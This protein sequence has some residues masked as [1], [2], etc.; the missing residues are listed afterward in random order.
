MC[1]IGGVGFV[2]QNR[3]WQVSF[4]KILEDFFSM[5]QAG[6]DRG[7][8]GTGVVLVWEDGTFA[9]FAMPVAADQFIESRG[10]GIL[11]MALKAQTEG[12][13]ISWILSCNRAQPIPE[14]DS[15]EEENLQPL[16][17]ADR[18]GFHNGT[19][20]N[21]HELFQQYALSRSTDVDSEVFLR[22]DDYFL[23]AQ[24]EQAAQGCEEGC[25]SMPMDTFDWCPRIF[26]D[27]SV[28]QRV[29]REVAGGIAFGMVRLGDPDVL[30]LLKNFKPLS[31]GYLDTLGIVLFNSERKNLEAGFGS[32]DLFSN[33]KVEH[34]PPYTGVQISLE[35]WGSC[36]KFPIQ[37]KIIASLPEQDENK[38]LVICSGGMD[39]STAATVAKR[40]HGRDTTLLHFN[41]QQLAFKSESRAVEA[42][43][44]EIGA[45]IMTIEIPWMGDLCKTPL[46]SKEVELPL[47]IASA[48]STKCWVP[49]RNLV[50]ISIAAAVAEARG[51]KYLYSGWNLEE[52]G[53][54]LDLPENLVRTG[55]HSRAISDLGKLPS[56]VKVG[57]RLVAWD[58]QESKI[59]YT[60]VQRVFEREHDE[61]FELTVG[62]RSREEGRFSVSGEHPFYTVGAGWV[63][64]R[65]IH[66]GMEIHA[67]SNGS[68]VG[69]VGVKRIRRKVKTYNYYCEPHNNFFLGTIGLLT[70]NSYPDNDLEFFQHL[71]E[72]FQYGTLTRVE[73]C[74]VL[75]RFM[76]AEIVKLAHHIS[77]PLDKTWSCD[78][79]GA[80]GCGKCGCCFTR[81]FAF[82][83][84]GIEDPQTY[85]SD[86]V[87]H[88]VWWEKKK[89]KVNATPV[90]ELV[91][92]V[93]KDGRG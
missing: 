71:A 69:V 58:E 13:R 79:G 9:K 45:E 26:R 25:P 51:F 65:E 35:Q 63:K 55:I 75:E 24:A 87:D 42:V 31:L 6:Q 30:L 54:L 15:I 34:V 47:G 59:S 1:T 27:F 53:C 3:A 48:E 39:S 16:V 50:M 17:I 82:I 91:R 88:P 77:V 80:R 37:T 84:A 56:E 32:G 12:L 81:K 7:S 68:L 67:L 28:V 23:R 43:A 86:E 78:L 8:D 2:Q 5:L 70:H 52:S 36:E 4:K 40:I 76:K 22:M 62:G 38:A 66:G 57:D 83:K 92:R 60:T 93:S 41:Y 61:Y 64:A 14:G 90:E 33:L 72:V 19:I 89:Y 49:A 29:C 73:M 18:V 74:L 44:K 85:L 10:Q 20:S 11:D 21:D 46:T